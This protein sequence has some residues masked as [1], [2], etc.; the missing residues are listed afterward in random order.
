[1]SVKK[2]V[3]ILENIEYGSLELIAP[4][5]KKYMFN[6]KYSGVDAQIEIKDKR[7]I[8][9]IFA[10]G[11]VALARTY[12]DGLWE[13]DNLI[14]LLEFGIQNEQATQLNV[15]TKWTKRII[16]QIYYF[17][18]RNTLQGS[19]KNI[20]E[21][22]DLGNEFYELWL[23]N[24]MTYSSGIFKTHNETLE[25]S[26]MNKYDR[27][28]ERLGKSDKQTVL[29]IGCG[30]GGFAQRLIDTTK[31]KITGITLS[32]EQ[33]KYARERLK[34]HKSRA[35]I[36]IQD[37]REQNKKFDSIVSIEMFEAVGEEYWPTYFNKISNSLNENGKAIIQAITIDEK[38][39]D[40]YRTGSDMIRSFI[41]PGGMLPSKSRF[42]MEAEKAGL[43]INELY[44]FGQSYAITLEHWLK[45]FNENKQ[46]IQKQNKD[47]RF[48]RI[49]EF[50]LA[51][52]IAGFKSGRTNV[53]QVEMSHA[54]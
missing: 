17:F 35:E 29:E 16:A 28:I 18:R 32:N 36:L 51:F 13:T 43:K 20:A 10:E 6:G 46:E 9:D 40:L 52:C 33:Y 27:I 44:E 54:A 7:A 30:W 42:K 3:K 14:N 47:E 48:M 38:E 2:L 26:Q 45:R 24:S 34:E 15:K 1:M 21:H 5:Q 11:N 22:Y 31:H 41:F 50:Y 37:Y 12:K 4:N 19:K 39:F 49:W 25:E 8:V 53:M 23:D